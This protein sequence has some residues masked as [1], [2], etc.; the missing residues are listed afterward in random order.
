MRTKSI[1]AKV[2]SVDDPSKSGKILASLADMDGNAYSEWIGPVFPASW[3]AMPEPGD[4][5]EVVMPA[6]NTDLIEFPEEVRYRGK[7][8]T[9]AYPVPDEFK[10]NY[11]KRRG[12][13]TAAG[14]ILIVDDE[15]GTV[16]L[17]NGKSGDVIEMSESGEISLTAGTKVH[18]NSNRS[19]LSSGSDSWILKGDI[20]KSSL[21]TFISGWTSA[22]S[23]LSSSGGTPAGVVAYAGAMPGLL[24]TLLT[25]INT[26]WLS[27]KVKT[28]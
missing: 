22:L 7:I 23:A 26:L 21:A 9:D 16:S 19:D 4:T 25:S 13:K 10:T 15:A 8:L 5:V 17:S 28:G 2:E 3:I 20:V 11:P 27:T 6:E 18:L 14:H 24:T 12:F 1:K